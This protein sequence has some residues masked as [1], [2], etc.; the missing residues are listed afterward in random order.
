MILLLSILH[1]FTLIECK[2]FWLYADILKRDKKKKRE[3][4][5]RERWSLMFSIK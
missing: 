4:W 5:E 2:V 3:N 1:F